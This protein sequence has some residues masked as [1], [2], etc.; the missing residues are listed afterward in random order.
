MSNYVCPGTRWLGYVIHRP[1]AYSAEWSSVV[2]TDWCWRYSFVIAYYVLKYLLAYYSHTFPSWINTRRGSIDSKFVPLSSALGS[3]VPGLCPCLV[4]VFDEEERS[5]CI[6]SPIDTG[7]SLEDS[8]DRGIPCINSLFQ[9][10]RHTYVMACFFYFATVLIQAG[11][12]SWLAYAHRLKAIPTS[13]AVSLVLIFLFNPRS[14]KYFRGNPFWWTSQRH[15]GSTTTASMT[16]P[17]WVA[18]K[19]F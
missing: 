13:Q 11:L 9:K 16:L 2:K 14:M 3:W 10:D 5:Q 17:H 1:C 18:W 19:A 12:W 15:D 7:G 4:G 8:W 6:E